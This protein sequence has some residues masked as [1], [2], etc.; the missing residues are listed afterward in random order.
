MNRL[1]ILAEDA[2]KYAHLAHASD[3]EQLEIRQTDNL[4]SAIAQ[5][6]DVNIVLGDPPLI[7]EVLSATKCLQW[8]QS[9]WAGVEQ[10][11]QPHLRRDYVLT[12]MKDVFGP[13][14]SE[15]VITYLFALERRVFEMQ[16][17]QVDKCWEPFAYRSSEDI[18]LGIIGLGSIGQHL[19]KTARRFGIRVTGLNLSGKPCA[20]VEQVFNW[21]SMADFLAEPDYVVI[22]LPD[23]PQTR[24][25]INAEVL[26]MMK[27]AAVLINVGRGSVVNENDLIAALQ[28]HTIGG[29][30]LDVFETEPLPADNPLWHLPN[31]Y[32]TPHTAAV[33]LP[34]VVVNKFVEN[35]HRF[36]RN[37][38]LLDVIDFARGY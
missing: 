9:S 8:V 12:G 27:P 23:T 17:K 20:E 38:P 32:I 14:I 11:C 4:E 15:Y 26:G 33:S 19:A 22:T 6:V 7:G 30:V 37:E 1:L 34:G 35:Y 28:Q 21:A 24:H 10:L 3:L 25:C 13:M 29:A 2:E 5:I 16:A 36:L 18:V 31:V